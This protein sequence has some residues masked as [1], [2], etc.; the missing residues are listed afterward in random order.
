MKLN[1][2]VESRNENNFKY[3]NKWVLEF[4]KR[5]AL[6]D[7]NRINEFTS[8]FGGAMR[9]EVSYWN[10]NRSK[11]AEV[12]WLENYVFKPEISSINKICNA[13]AVKFVGRPTLT[14]KAC[15]TH[16]YNKI[17]DFEKYKSDLKYY[18]WI[19]NNLDNDK[20]N[21]PVWGTTQ[22]QTSLQ[23]AAR[24]YVREV[25]KTPT[26]KF[27]LSHMIRWISHLNNLGMT[28][29]VTNPNNRLRDVVYWLKEFRGIGPYFSYHPPCNFSRDK[30]LPHIDENDDIC[31]IGPGAKRGLEYVWPDVKFT[32]NNIMEEYILSVRDYQ[33]EFFEFK[34][35]DQEYYK[36]NLERGGNLTTFGTEITFCQFSVFLDIK[37]NPIA[38]Q[39]RMLPL[40]FD[41]YF[42][43][44]NDLYERKNPATLSEFML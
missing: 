9:P 39:K 8:T 7:S 40:R 33:H 37:D 27:K 38:Q 29:I 14:L 25:D 34:N 30:D 3:F 44:A 11:H 2:L 10:P 26:I 6:R 42:N 23:T 16:D 12:Y 5:E 20:W 43:I 21:I 15:D 13:M 4:F 18:E 28:D 1:K 24:N 17:I 31:T 41:E 22:L 36:M 32:N 35:D 19:N